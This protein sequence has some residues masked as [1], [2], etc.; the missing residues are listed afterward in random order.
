MMPEVRVNWP[1]CCAC[2]QA[3]KG[4]RVRWGMATP[5]MTYI[6]PSPGTS[7]ICERFL[8]RSLLI[9]SV[10]ADRADES[11]AIEMFLTDALPKSR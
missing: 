3:L 1:F 6:Q 11:D 8:Y 4:W 9:C 7:V 2:T 5:M 10:A